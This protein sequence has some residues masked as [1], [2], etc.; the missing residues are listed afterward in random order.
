MVNHRLLQPHCDRPPHLQSDVES[1][2]EEGENDQE[3]ASDIH[4]DTAVLHELTSYSED[5]LRQAEET[6]EGHDIER[7]QRVRNSV[8]R[9]TYFIEENKRRNVQ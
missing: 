3:Q 7:P 6:N 2:D 9:L 4:N 5:D 8:P 1:E